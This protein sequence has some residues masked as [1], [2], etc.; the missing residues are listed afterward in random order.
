MIAEEPEAA[1]VVGRGE[2]PQ[3]QAPEQLGEHAHV[4]EEA[5]PAGHP[6]P[7]IER[8]AAARSDRSCMGRPSPDG[9]SRP[10]F[11]RSPVR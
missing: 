8:D 10:T 11:D 4:Q 1:G 3:E 9:R 6:P 2:P 7:T 5:R